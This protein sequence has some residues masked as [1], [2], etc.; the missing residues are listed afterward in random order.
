MLF[1]LRSRGRRRTVQAVYLSLAIVM[2]GGLVL[3]GVGTGS[4]GGLLDAFKGGGSD[5]AASQFVTQQEKD[6][7]K[8]AKLNPNDPAPWGAL[9]SDRYSAAGQ[10]SGYDVATQTYTAAGKKELAKAG[11]AWQHYLQLQPHPDYNVALIAAR[12]YESSEDFSNA[13]R[14]WEIVAAANPTTAAYYANLAA[15]AY[16][17]KQTR[18]GDLAAAK[19]V[20]LSPKNQQ[21]LIKQQLQAAKAKAAQPAQSATVPGK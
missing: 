4:G 8:A 13:A 9:V 16:R 1:D 7:L 3:F 15:D 5:N 17:A 11:D 12:V 20:S 2:G 10:G 6:H 14:A 21:T 18:K 19:A